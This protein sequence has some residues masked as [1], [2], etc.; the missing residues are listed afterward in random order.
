MNGCAMTRKTGEIE[1]RHLRYFVAAC[2]HGSFRKAAAAVGVQES[3]ISRRIRDYEDSIGVSLFHRHNC[4]VSQTLAGERCLRRAR[5]ILRYIGE[6]DE[7]ISSIGRSEM[8]RVRVGIFSSLASGFLSDLLRTY[9]LKHAGVEID[10]I[11]GNPSEH[12]SAIRQ[13][14]L[15]VAFVTGTQGWAG[16]DTNFLWNERVFAVLPQGHALV[17]REELEWSDLAH[18]TFIVSEEAPGQEIHD[19][20]VHRLADLGHHPDIRRQGVGRDNLFPLVALGKGLTLTSEA[21]TAAMFPGI[22]YRPIAGEVLPFSAV[23]SP[24]NDNPALRRLLSL[25]KSLSKSNGPGLS[26]SAP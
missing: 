12:V 7:D 14:K 9:G 11:V 20:L 17:V 22:I 8:G 21:T 1:L 26:V 6:G 25:A 10:F 16:C 13:L 15:D 5:K 23:W 18:E 2:E 24:K 19:Y 4:G 3:S